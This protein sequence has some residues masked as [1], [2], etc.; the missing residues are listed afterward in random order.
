MKPDDDDALRAAVAEAHRSDAQRTPSFDQ[1]W[2]TARRSGRPRPSPLP[3]LV[4]CAALATAAG[5]AVWLVGRL[6]PPPAQLPTGTSW[7]GPTD[8]LLEIPG[9]V[10][11]RTVPD[12]VPSF[13]DP[14]LRP[15]PD[16]RRGN[17]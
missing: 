1:A 14:V 3:W 4:T 7:K 15:D 9:L 11:L 5:L 8:F 2:A 10:T 12:L 6:G 16:A 17:P 13:P